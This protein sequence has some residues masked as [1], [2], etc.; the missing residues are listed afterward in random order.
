MTNDCRHQLIFGLP[1]HSKFLTM[2][3]FNLSSSQLT[4][5]S[6][7]HTRDHT[8][9]TQIKVNS[10][11]D[12]EIN[13]DSHRQPVESKHESIRSEKK[14]VMW[15]NNNN[16]AEA[17]AVPAPNRIRPNNCIVRW[18]QHIRWMWMLYERLFPPHTPFS[19]SPSLTI[20][21]LAASF[22]CS[23]PRQRSPWLTMCR[24][25]RKVEWLLRMCDGY[26][27]VVLFFSLSFAAKVYRHRTNIAGTRIHRTCARSHARIVIQQQQ[28]QQQK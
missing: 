23:P 13:C 11:C 9:N 3:P 27:V 25:L 8:N 7:M 15:N 12:Y 18:L 28:Q 17:A 5:N 2:P 10:R 22:S 21:V 4:Q 14:N 20:A 6:H 16:S 26:D 24:I 19:P 1:T